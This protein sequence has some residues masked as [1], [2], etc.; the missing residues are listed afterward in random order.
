[1][2][3]KKKLRSYQKV[4]VQSL[5]ASS[6]KELATGMAILI[7]PGAGIVAGSYLIYKAIKNRSKDEGES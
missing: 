2:I 5:K 3:N 1:M 6:K 4:I 7:L